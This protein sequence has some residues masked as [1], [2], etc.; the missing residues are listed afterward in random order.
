VE[1][2][3]NARVD[4]YLDGDPDNDPPFIGTGRPGACRVC[5]AR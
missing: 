4:L 1:P 2:D 5:H 3:P